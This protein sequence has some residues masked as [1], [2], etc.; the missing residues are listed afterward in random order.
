MVRV[1][2]LRDLSEII[3]LLRRGVEALEQLAQES[4]KIREALDLVDD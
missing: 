2:G 1:I 4:T 3:G